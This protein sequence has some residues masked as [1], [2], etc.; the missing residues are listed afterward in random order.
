MV[1]R[2]VE[3]NEQ[4]SNQLFEVLSEWETALQDVPDG[5]EPLP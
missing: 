3:L 5:L 2:M 1:L 4:E